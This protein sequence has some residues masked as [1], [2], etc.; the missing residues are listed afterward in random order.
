MLLVEFS[1]PRTALRE[2]IVLD[3]VCLRAGT[4]PGKGVEAT[5]RRLARAA[6]VGAEE[7]R[8]RSRIADGSPRLDTSSSA[9]EK[10]AAV[11][12][13]LLLEMLAS[14]ELP[15][16][17]PLLLPVLVL[18]LVD[19]VASVAACVMPM[20]RGT[21]LLLLFEDSRRLD[22]DRFDLDLDRD[23]DEPRRRDFEGLSP[24]DDRRS[25]TSMVVGMTSMVWLLSPLRRSLIVGFLLVF[26]G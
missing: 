15:S 17:L 21:V 10:Y 2:V 22:D 11:H 14:L 16:P 9:T 23:V 24:L 4:D 26:C 5:R 19:T 7:G 25:K 18:V 1:A 20:N 6:F 3:L 12:A 8:G 13:L